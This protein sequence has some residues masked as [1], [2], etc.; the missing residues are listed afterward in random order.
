MLSAVMKTP[1]SWIFLMATLAVISSVTA[2]HGADGNWEFHFEVTGITLGAF[3]LI[4]LPA[5]LRLLSLTGGRFKGAGV[6][7]SSGGLIGTPDDL[8][9]DLTRIRTEAEEASRQP[10]PTDVDRTLR[11]LQ[12]Q[13]DEMAADYLAESNA[14]SRA[15]IARLADEYESIRNALQSGERRTIEMTRVINE[16]RVRASAN[17]E[18]ARRLAPNLVNS[19]REGER[20]IGLA[21]LQ[22]IQSPYLLKAI[23]SRIVASTSAFEMFHAL[24]ALREVAPSLELHQVESVVR[25]LKKEKTDYRGVAVMK[26]PNLPGLIDEVIALLEAPAY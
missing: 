5:L 2:E 7:L 6:E 15:T 18:H 11:Q 9:G 21:F 4:W 3:A 20:L 13:V 14:L 25:I 10:D 19:N 1:R 17:P 26:D 24:I 16:A 23:V 12:Q 22:E 8:I